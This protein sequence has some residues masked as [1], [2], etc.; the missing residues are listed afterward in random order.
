MVRRAFALEVL[1]LPRPVIL[2]CQDGT[3]TVEGDLRSE[4]DHLITSS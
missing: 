3:S 1:L 4:A 2:S